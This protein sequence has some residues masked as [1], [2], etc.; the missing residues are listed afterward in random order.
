[1][2]RQDL[3]TDGRIILAF[4]EATG[5]CHQVLTEATGL[6]PGMAEA[7]YFAVDSTDPHVVGEL[8][9]LAPCVL[10]HGTIDGLSPDHAP[11]HLD[12]T[13]PEPIRQGDVFLLP[14]GSGIWEVRRQADITP[15]AWRMVAD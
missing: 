2:N 8:I 13:Y 4:G 9:V 14:K 15:D 6:P 7:Q 3:R 12:P 5:H 11:L 10:Q 1:M